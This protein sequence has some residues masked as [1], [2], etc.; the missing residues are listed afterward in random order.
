MSPLLSLYRS[1]S[2]THPF[3]L[4]SLRP[5]ERRFRAEVL[6]RLSTRLPSGLVLAVGGL[7]VGGGGEGREGAKEEDVGEGGGGGGEGKG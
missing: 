2:H 5:T 1:V 4:P 3:C 6:A 7:S